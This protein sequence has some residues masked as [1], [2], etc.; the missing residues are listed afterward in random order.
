MYTSSYSTSLYIPCSN[1]SPIPPSTFCILH[2]ILCHCTYPVTPLPATYFVNTLLYSTSLYIPCSS[3]SPPPTLCILH[4]ILR[5]CT[6]PVALYP[7]ILPSLCILHPTLRHCTN[8]V[9]TPFPRP[10][11]CILHITLRHCANPVAPPSPTTYFVNSLLCST[12]LYMP[13]GSRLPQHLLCAY[14][15]FFYVTVHTL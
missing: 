14:F 11:L 10:T 3:L 9:A 4:F 5:H 13:S 12:S 15:T 8:P 7:S 2:F 6:Y 1:P